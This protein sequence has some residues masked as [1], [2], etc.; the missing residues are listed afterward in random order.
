MDTRHM[1]ATA[2][3]AGASTV[4]FAGETATQLDTCVDL[5]PDRDIVHQGDAS[6]FTLRDGDVRYRVTLR[7]TC[8]SL[9]SA[10]TVSIAA[11]GT[12]GRIC[13]RGTRVQ[14]RDDL[15]AVERIDEIDAGYRIAHR[16]TDTTH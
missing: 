5:G 12:D 7:E 6:S 2:L 3:L 14:T 15:C 10:R 13:P 4:A 16:D 11:H 9:R 1:I 8:T